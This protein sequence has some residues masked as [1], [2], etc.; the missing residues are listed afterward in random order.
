MSGTAPGALSF[1][2]AENL[3]GAGWMPDVISTDIHQLSIRG[4]MFDLPTC[5]SKF[6]CLGMDLDEV[7]K[8]TTIRPAEVVGLPDGLGS[9]KPGTPADIALFELTEGE[10]VFHDVNMDKRT[11]KVML[12]NTQTLVGGRPL[13]RVSADPPAPWV[14]DE[15]LWPQAH[16]QM[17]HKQ[18]GLDAK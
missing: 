4:P 12:R 15:F 17:V 16:A 2:I 5:M 8:A 7:V 9:L 6:L 11:G 14:T 13:T 18:W 3:I 10:F 1:G